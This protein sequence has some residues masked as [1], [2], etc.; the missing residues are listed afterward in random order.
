MYIT[1]RMLIVGMFLVLALSVT[2]WVF[3][4]T[5]GLIYACVN[6]AGTLRIVTDSESCLP[7]ET[8]L[9][10][11]KQGVKGDKGDQGDVGP[12]GPQGPA[13]VLDFYVVEGDHVACE[14]GE[15][16]VLYAYCNQGDLITGGGIRKASWYAYDDPGIGIVTMEPYFDTAKDQWTYLA[17]VNNRFNFNEDFWTYAMC[18]EMP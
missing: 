1:K 17:A 13:G 11:N 14:P 8:L 12:A 7:Q 16:C 2:T 9:E 5:D 3:A 4:Q 15:L 6:P 10:W 18:A